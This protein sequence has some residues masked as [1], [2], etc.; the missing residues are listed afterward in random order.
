MRKSLTFLLGVFV[1]VAAGQISALAASQQID[2][3]AGSTTMSSPN[4]ASSKVGFLSATQIGQQIAEAKQL[5]RSQPVTTGSAPSAS[6]MLATLDPE[7]SQID[8]LSV[9]K[10]SFLIKGAKLPATTQLGRS[11]QVHVINPNGVNTAVTVTETATGRSFFPLVVKYPIVKGGVLTDFALYT[12]AH[13]ALLSAELVSA[14]ENYLRTMLDSAV[15]RLAEDGVTVSP[16]IVAVAEHL[17]IV[18]HTDHKRFLNDNRAAL[19]PEILSLYALNQGETYRYSI[20]S[21]GAGGMIQMIPRT[22]EA[23][24]QHHAGV[25][26]EPDFVRGMSDH[27]NALRA[28]LLYINDTWN[29][30]QQST[31]VQ[32]AL[33]NGT[34]T[35]PELLAA[36][37]NSNPYRLPIYLAR[38]GTGWR[39]LIP[40]ETQLYLAIYSS[41]DS[42]VQFKEVAAQD[43]ALDDSSTNQPFGAEA[44]LN[45]AKALLV[46]WLSNE[47]L[48]SSSALSRVLP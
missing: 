46:S 47:L 9:P 6:V 18:E 24:R 48:R 13:P 22:Y 42:T 41:V 15:N 8:L 27:A 2:A 30:L 16:D 29:Y 39:T 31:E 43:I 40:A 11:V 35:K 20:S 12:S 23:I 3:V 25:D 19:S 37:Y 44:R 4:A 33:S 45:N 21:A 5:L 7:S 26:L 32:A 28:M 36:G 14:G 17:C 1:C 10:D 34:A 38:G